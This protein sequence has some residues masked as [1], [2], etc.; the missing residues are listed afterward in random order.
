MN[1]LTA[2]NLGRNLQAALTKSVHFTVQTLFSTPAMPAIIG[3]VGAIGLFVLLS[4]V[5]LAKTPLWGNNVKI[6]VKP[7]VF[8]A[9]EGRKWVDQCIKIH[10][11]ILLLADK[12]VRKTEEGTATAYGPYSEQLFGEVYVEFDRTLMTIHCLRLILEGSQ[13]AYSLFT[14]NQTANAKLSFEDFQILHK[15]GTRLLTSKWGGLTKREVALAMETALVLGDIGKSAKAR[16]LFKK[17]AITAPDHDDFYGEAMKILEKDPKICVSFA[18]LPPAAKK[19]LVKIANLA[20]YGHITHLEGDASMFREL[21]ESKIA[22]ED[23]LALSFNLFVHTADVAGALGHVNNRS[24]VV[25]NERAHRAMQAMNRAV[26]TLSDPSKTEL[27]AYTAYVKERADWLGLDAK[28]PYDRVLARIGAMLRLFTPSD[29]AILK[30]AL[31][32][33]PAETRALIV[34]ELDASADAQPTRTP[35]YMPAVLI[36]L[37]NNTQLGDNREACLA[38]AI[39]LGLPFIARVLKKHKELL[40]AQAIDP[41]IPLNFNPIAGIAK[42]KPHL[43]SSGEF[44]IDSEGNIR[45][46]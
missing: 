9:L 37:L 4:G 6:V 12:D 40:A 28:D 19:L 22:V 31:Q 42:S 1:S 34:A 7:V 21:R 2:K 35:T 36:N 27:E 18:R 17:Y 3:R 29:G 8:S 38:Q 5:W 16:E 30:Q 46:K 41:N 11:E 14:E 33:L 39:Q 43:L 26:L 25:Y 45:L 44:T 23:P 32:K 24:S 10:P 20:H 13:E 15:Q